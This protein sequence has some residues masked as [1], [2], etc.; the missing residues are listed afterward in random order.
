MNR[1][2]TVRINA[3]QAM[4]TE[5]LLRRVLAITLMVA[6]VLATIWVLSLLIALV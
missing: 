1:N 5:R 2:T 3:K 4:P 6:L